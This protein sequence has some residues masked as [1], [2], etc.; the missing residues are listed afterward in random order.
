MAGIPSHLLIPLRKILTDCEQFETNRS[1]R[2]VFADERLTPYRY[3]LP[4]T[5]GI[6]ERVD[7]TISYL[8]D[9][10][11]RDGSN[12]LVSLLLV[13]AE[14]M[15]EGDGRREILRSLAGQLGDVGTAIR[16]QVA[17]SGGKPAPSKAKA[18]E[19]K[20]DTAAAEKRDF[21]ISYNR[22][23]K[24]WAEW[25][26]W[27]LENAGY[28]TYLQAWDFRPGGNFVADMQEAAEKSER[29]IAV[30]SETYLTSPFTK[31]EWSVAFA[32]DPE[33]KQG[34]LLPI[35]G[36]KCDPKG[37][38]TSI[39][40]IDL[41]GLAGEQAAERLL[42]GIN[43]GRDKPLVPPVF[44]GTLERAEPPFPGTS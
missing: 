29:T 4:Q 34:L 27:Q 16:S 38:L 20:P 1:L 9:K 40:Y 28:T 31:S 35:K 14:G 33:G 39:V 8:H 3:S 37:L 6:M 10:K 30:L 22:H 19:A 21:F 13:L 7:S 26:A 36:R 43:R 5:D 12:A 41:M 15:D 23:D 24:D 42:A 44:P 32:R 11:H 25:I 18:T 2:S 17:A